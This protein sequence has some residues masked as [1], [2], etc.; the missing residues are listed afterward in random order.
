MIELITL[1]FTPFLLYISDKLIYW[2]VKKENFYHSYD[3][4]D[5]S[6]GAVLIGRAL[7]FIGCQYLGIFF[8]TPCHVA[9][10]ITTRM[11]K[12]EC[13]TKRVKFMT[14]LVWGSA[15][16]LGFLIDLITFVTM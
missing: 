6:A 10:C 11:R 13:Y 12:E 9:E 8:S 16:W 7:L 15:D 5:F 1:K 4:Y 3:I 2:K 14:P